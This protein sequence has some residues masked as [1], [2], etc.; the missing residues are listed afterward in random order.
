MLNTP[1][2]LAETKTK[3]D[4]ILQLLNDA[5][6]FHLS[7]SNM[8]LQWA[9]VII[10]ILSLLIAGASLLASYNNFGEAIKSVFKL[11]PLLRNSLY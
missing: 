6:E 5:A 7:K 1:S 3:I 10:T 9:M 11:F 8:A 2:L 4:N